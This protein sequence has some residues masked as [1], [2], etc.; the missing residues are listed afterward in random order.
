[1]ASGS[2]RA[3][4]VVQHTSAITHLV[5]H[6]SHTRI[7]GAFVEAQLARPPF[8]LRYIR[9]QTPLA[10][11]LIVRDNIR[12]GSSMSVTSVTHP[13]I[14]QHYSKKVT[15]PYFGAEFSMEALR[16]ANPCS[17]VTEGR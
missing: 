10:H 8:A 6:I 1:M 5:R 9:P 11:P 3:H 14:N 16:S 15:L 7:L 12:A 17:I 2:R 13:E 4:K